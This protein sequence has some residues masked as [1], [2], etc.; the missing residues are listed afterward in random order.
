LTTQAR[1]PGLEWIHREV[2]FNYRLTNLH[3]AVGVAQLEQLD[4]FVD[5]KRATADAYAK[6]LPVLGGVTPFHEAA[7][8]RST[9]WMS[10]A[11]FDDGWGDVRVLVARGNDGGIGLRP[12][13]RPLHRQPAFAGCR[14]DRIDVADRLYARGASLPCSVG[15][16]PDEREAVVAA[17]GALRP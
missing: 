7:W 14:T 9:Y 12:L 3:A 2:G 15:I 17:L 1:D 5:A 11:L 4:A 6:A 13:W 16:T 10:S 8:A